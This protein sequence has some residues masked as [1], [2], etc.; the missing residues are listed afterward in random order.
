MP[1]SFRTESYFRSKLFYSMARDA[2][3]NARI[4]EEC[5]FGIVALLLSRTIVASK[6]CTYSIYTPLPLKVAL[7]RTLRAKEASCVKPMDYLW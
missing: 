5:L 7:L 3:G 1:S 2:I 6:L 4:V